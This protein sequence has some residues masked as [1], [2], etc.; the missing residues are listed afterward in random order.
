MVICSLGSLKK[1]P[2]RKKRVYIY[3]YIYIYKKKRVEVLQP[4][5]YHRKRTRKA[6][7]IIK[8]LALTLYLLTRITLIL[9]S[10]SAIIGSSQRVNFQWFNIV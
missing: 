2:R 5:S 4:A 10:S 3:I 7:M 8:Y 6:V 1:F 9:I